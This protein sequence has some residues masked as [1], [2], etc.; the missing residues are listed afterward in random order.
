MQHDCQ[1]PASHHSSL[2]RPVI[3]HC[4]EQL[5][6]QLQK[7]A[8]PGHP[9]YVHHCDVGLLRRHLLIPKLGWR[10]RGDYTGFVCFSRMVPMHVAVETPDYL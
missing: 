1:E 7:C 5:P 8:Q 3:S 6:Y 2:C 9:A 4:H 10:V